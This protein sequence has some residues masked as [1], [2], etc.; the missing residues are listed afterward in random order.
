M[1]E[2]QVFIGTN[3]VRGSRGIYSLN[4]SGGALSLIS[5]RDAYNTGALALSRDGG[6]LYAASEGMSFQ[7]CASGGAMAFRVEDGGALSYL[8]GYPTMG[9]RPCCLAVDDKDRLLAANF[10]GGSLAVFPTAPGGALE[11]MERLAKMPLSPGGRESLHCVDAVGGMPGTVSAGTHELLLLDGVDLHIISR[12]PVPERMF[13][14]HF[15]AG[16][17]GRYI[18]LLMQN[19]GLIFVLKNEPDENG[20]LPCVQEISVI[21][22]D[23][24]GMYGT[25]TL[26][27][28]PDGG[29]LLAATRSADTIAVFSVSASDGTLTLTDM[30]RLPGQTPRDFCLTPDGR[31]AVTALQASDQVCV[32]EL[33]Y[34]A[35]RLILRD[36][37][38]NIPSPAAV[39]IRERS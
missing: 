19:P 30:A 35:G 9:Q 37:M 10:Y 31:F 17:G 6:T 36:V 34:A 32:H 4:L 8:N 25:S 14:R 3:S 20:V 27:L 29:C 22:P 23:Y 7:G 28:T 2:Y 15:R 21:P 1:S 24:Q 5:C 13:P 39:A 11:P 38:D 16:D 33:D 12:F 18:Y 26:H